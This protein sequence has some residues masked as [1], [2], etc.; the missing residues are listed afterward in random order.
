MTEYFEF[1]AALEMQCLDVSME[2]T[3]ICVL[4]R[5][6]TLIREGKKRSSPA[7]IATILADGPP[8]EKVVFETGRMASMASVLCAKEDRHIGP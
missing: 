7:A 3:R 8:F 6:G 1:G 2:E 4:D 5:E